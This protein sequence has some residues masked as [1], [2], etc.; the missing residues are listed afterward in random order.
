MYIAGVKR[1]VDTGDSYFNELRSLTESGSKMAKGKIGERANIKRSQMYAGTPLEA[2][3]EFGR[4][5]VDC[6]NCGNAEFA[7]EDNLFFCSN[8]KN[9]DIEGRVRRVKLPKERK[10][11]EVI[12]GK[13]QIV[14]RHWLPSET[15]ASLQK[16]NDKV[17]I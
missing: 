16:E 4:W 15:V 14:N 12:L 1:A 3:A 11:I 2:R 7:F 6:P 13:R 8:C 5:I 17:V 10:E 9:S